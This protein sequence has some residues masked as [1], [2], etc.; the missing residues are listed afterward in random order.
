MIDVVKFLERFCSE[1]EDGITFC[2]NYSGRGMD[3]RTCV[4]IVVTDDT[5]PFDLALALAGYISETEYVM[6]HKLHEVLGGSCM[7][8][9]GLG[10]IIYFPCTV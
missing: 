8:S 7:D 2:E 10:Y 1:Y 4:G 5:Q 9:M 3:G 6:P